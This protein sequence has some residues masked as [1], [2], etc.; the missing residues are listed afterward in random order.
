MPA[1]LA[2]LISRP[3]LG[4]VFLAGESRWEVPDSGQEKKREARTATGSQHATG[5]GTAPGRLVPGG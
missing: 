4:V 1:D 2:R 3:T 5:P